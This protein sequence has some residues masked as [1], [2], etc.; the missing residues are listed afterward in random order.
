[1]S[2]INVLPSSVFNRISA[3][4]V[5]ERPC[6][7]AKELIENAIDAGA[8]EIDVTV[9][10]GGTEL[11]EVTDNGSGISY[12]DLKKA[13]LPHATSK[14]ADVED[15]DRI[16]TLG[17][18]GEALASIGAVS[19]STIISKTEDVEAGGMIR[20]Y[21]GSLSDVEYF[22]VKKGLKF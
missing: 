10:N 4:E 15:L 16:L 3:G 22:R 19:K 2:K 7:V 6:S 14:I 17:F 13:F 11:I 8:T 12:D 20:C 9:T 1:M 18:R 21:G 5:V